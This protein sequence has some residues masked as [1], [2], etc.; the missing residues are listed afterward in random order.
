MG[1]PN[2]GIRERTEGAEGVC[3]PIGRTTIPTNQAARAPRDK[4]TNQGVHM[5]EPIA[6]AGHLAEDNLVRHEWEER[7]LV[8]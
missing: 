7:P 8:L 4:A 5:E 2:I 3:N 1:V 6:P